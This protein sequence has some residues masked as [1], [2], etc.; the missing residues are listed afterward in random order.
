[1]QWS[2]EALD[3]ALVEIAPLPPG[4]QGRLLRLFDLVEAHGVNA[5]HEPHARKVEGQLWGLRVSPR[6]GIARGLYVALSGQRVIVLHVFEK[7]TQKTP[8]RSIDLAWSR[9]RD[10]K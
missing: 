3:A 7:K 1:M 4:L 2:V 6:E 9:M 10:I 5:L 8:R